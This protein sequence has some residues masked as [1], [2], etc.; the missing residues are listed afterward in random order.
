MGRPGGD[1]L[2]QYCGPCRLC[3]FCERWWLVGGL[4]GWL[5][6][7]REGDIQSAFQRVIGR[8][9]WLPV[10]SQHR[11][12]RNADRDGECDRCS[13][14]HT[15]SAS[16]EEVGHQITLSLGKA[17]LP[18]PVFSRLSDSDTY[19]AA[20]ERL[21]T[22]AESREVDRRAIE[23]CGVAGFDLM[24]RAARFACDVFTARWPDAVSACVLAGRGNN[25]GDGYVLAAMLQAIG[26]HVTLLQ[27][28]P[29]PDRGDGALAVAYA[30]ERGVEA[31]SFVGAVVGDVIVDA[32]LGTGVSGALRAPYAQAVHSINSASRPVLAID[33]PTGLSA[34]SGGAVGDVEEVV[35]ADVTATFIT[36]K[37]GQHTGL[38]LEVCGALHYHDLNTPRAAFQGG[39]PWLREVRSQEPL[40]VNSYKHARGHVVVVGGDTSMGGAVILAGEAALRSGA[41]MVT[42]ATRA[43]HRAA[44][45]A[46]RPELMVMEADDRAA[47]EQLLG[48][49]SAVVLG[50][51]LGRSMWGRSLFEFVMGHAPKRLLVDADGLFHLADTRQQGAAVI[52]PHVAE[53]AR[54][55]GMRAADVQ[56]DRPEAARLLNERYGA[57]VVLKGAGSVIAGAATLAICGRGT[58]AMATAGMGDVLCGVVAAGLRPEDERVFDALCNAVLNHAVAG[59]LA[60]RRLGH[61]IVASDLFME[62]ARL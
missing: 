42:L 38:G 46:R 58:P 6:A 5:C 12:Q 3:P 22:A 1:C 13:A 29:A 55:L 20:V 62:L 7:W 11:V 56:A 14:V 57:C 40:P 23:D 2:M 4:H 19:N 8:L 18:H 47:L 51:G 31:A 34:D 25:A 36:R 33:L 30:R 35:R 27:V 43:Q 21:Y 49:A 32:L 44:A 16:L 61:H 26:V 60:E 10:H 50:P 24:C 45:L 39:I 17:R 41:G 28:G 9:R 53:A 37:I 59:E 48:R 54:L 15:L 52:T